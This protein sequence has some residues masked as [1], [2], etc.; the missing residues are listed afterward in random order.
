MLRK[1]LRLSNSPSPLFYVYSSRKRYCGSDPTRLS[2]GLSSADEILKIEQDITRHAQIVARHEQIIIGLKNGRNSYLP[3]FKLPVEILYKIFQF[4]RDALMDPLQY[5][6]P[7]AGFRSRDLAWIAVTHVYQHW[8]DAAL[9]DPFLWAQPSLQYSKWTA[10]ML[11]RSQTADLRIVF[12]G[13]SCM[14]EE[15]LSTVI[16]HIPH[17]A[18]LI[19]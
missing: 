15:A 5:F 10:V 2:D 1:G 6:M 18:E 3:I 16:S 11:E 17:T 19:I 7:F 14:R 8:R 12:D 4:T 9:N 13:N